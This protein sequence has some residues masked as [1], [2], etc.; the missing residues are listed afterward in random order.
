MSRDK[1]I[2]LDD[3]Q[4]YEIKR[5]AVDTRH[6]LGVAHNVPI[7]NDIRL[8]LE[9]KDIILCEYPYP[10]VQ[11]THT[12]GNITW[13]KT[14][15][16]DITF[17]G[18]NTSGYYDEQIFALAHELYHYNTRTGRAYTLDT[19]SEDKLLE[20][21][22]DRFAAEL[23]LPRD[24]LDDAVIAFFDNSDV[25]KESD[26]RILRFVAKLQCD[27]W[28]PFQ[29]I[30]NRLLEEDKIDKKQFDR[31]YDLDCRSE[32]GQYRRLLRSNDAEIAEL[33]NKKTKTVG[34][35][36]KVI[37]TTI[38]NYEDGYIDDDEFYKLMSLFGKKPQ[39]Y[40]FDFLV[41]IDDDIK[42]VIERGV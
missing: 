20:K 21:K 14:E 35:S 5:L 17:I 3:R 38:N 36:G 34:I 25:R 12:Y 26:I 30:V 11:G 40:G 10:D 7:G 31:L 15:A 8:L 37:E 2:R 4:I 1:T 42:F 18:L 23:L 27:W 6:F 29:S 16:G 33:L 19:D 9:K 32:D 28:L 41:E 24:A 22:A 39:D 13:V